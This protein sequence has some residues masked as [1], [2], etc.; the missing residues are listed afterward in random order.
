MKSKSLRL[1]DDFDVVTLDEFCQRSKMP[2]SHIERYLLAAQKAHLLQGAQFQTR[3]IWLIADLPAFEAYR[4]HNKMKRSEPEI[5]TR[6]DTVTA[7]IWAYAGQKKLPL[8]GA[9]QRLKRILKRLETL[10]ARTSPDETGARVVKIV[11]GPSDDRRPNRRFPYREVERELSAATAKIKPQRPLKVSEQIALV[12]EII[13]L[14]PPT[15]QRPRSEL[16]NELIEKLEVD[17]LWLT[18]RSR[19]S[20]GANFSEFMTDLLSGDLQCQGMI[21]DTLLT[22]LQNP[23]SLPT[24]LGY[25]PEKKTRRR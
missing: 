21:D 19:H 4:K 12:Q 2:R 3:W 9:R 11:W 5:A 8:T 20:H 16:Q 25:V 14:I 10:Q 18:G 7:Q 6:A 13:T 23:A 15:G 22:G 1:D 24:L 17:H